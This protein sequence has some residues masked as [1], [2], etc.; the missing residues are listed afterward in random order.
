MVRILSACDEGSDEPAC[1]HE[2]ARAFASRIN[3][4][5]KLKKTPNNFQTSSLSGQN[6]RLLE[7]FSDMRLDQ[8]S[9]LFALFSWSRYL[10]LVPLNYNWWF[11][12]ILSGLKS[13]QFCHTDRTWRKCKHTLSQ[14]FHNISIPENEMQQVPSSILKINVYQAC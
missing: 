5:C 9:C 6:E 2:L 11:I 3:K 13:N 1:T 8:I 14:N 7:A 4:V 12:I 10:T